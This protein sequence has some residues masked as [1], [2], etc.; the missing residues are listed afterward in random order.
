MSCLVGIVGP[1]GSGKSTSFF[2]EAKLGI[3]GLDPTKT[4]VVNVSGKPFPFRGWRNS[5]A[6]F[7]RKTGNYLNSEDAGII[8]KAMV[9]V[10]EERPEI[11]NIVLDD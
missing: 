2:P 5:Y 6:P 1:A 3:V 8:S 9:I 7:N 11:T 4:F 10:S